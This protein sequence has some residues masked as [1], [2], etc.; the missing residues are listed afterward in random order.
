MIFPHAIPPNIP[1]NDDSDLTI[2]VNPNYQDPP[3]GDFAPNAWSN[4]PFSPTTPASEVSAEIF[5]YTERVT[6]KSN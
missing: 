2:L 6:P 3:S 5:R 1:P 4:H